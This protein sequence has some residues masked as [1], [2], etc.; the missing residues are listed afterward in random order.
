MAHHHIIAFIIAVAAVAAV[1]SSPKLQRNLKN[2]VS[3]LKTA[4]VQIEQSINR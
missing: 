3:N 1:L 4:V 2:A